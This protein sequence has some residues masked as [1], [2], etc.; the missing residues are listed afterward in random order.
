M[1]DTNETGGLTRRQ[2]MGATAAGGAALGS[3]A[4]GGI[5]LT[6]GGTGALMT[7]TGEAAA[8]SGSSSGA[9]SGHVAPG[10]LDEYYEIGRA[11]V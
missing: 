3:V 11:H 7:S 9:A 4:V 8:A 1:S 6:A 10:E 5:A 2:L